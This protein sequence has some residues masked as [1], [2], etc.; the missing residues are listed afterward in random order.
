MNPMQSELAPPGSG[1]P[2]DCPE[3]A[4]VVA[5]AYGL[6]RREIL[7]DGFRAE[8]FRCRGHLR[9]SGFSSAPYLTDGGVQVGDRFSPESAAA[10][11]AHCLEETGAQ[12]VL[13]RA[14]R[15]LFTPVADRLIVDPSFETYVLPLD[16]GTER[17]WKER[18]HGK[19]R[20]QIRKGQ[21]QKLEVRIGHLDLLDSFFAVITEA[22]RDLGTPS[23]A[24]DYF[25]RILTVFGDQRAAVVAVFHGS[26]P[27]STALLLVCGATLHHPYAA[28]LRAFND[29]S[30]NNVLYWSI[31]EYGCRRGCA[32]FDLGRSRVDQGTRRY[33]LSWGAEP[34]PLFYSYFLRPGA[35]VPDL[36]SPLFQFATAVWQRMPLAATR[37]LGPHLIR[38]IL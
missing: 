18:I 9:S 6:E 11:A 30:A 4:E 36:Q 2:A 29:L 13:L 27:I 22:W 12:H 21:R 35:H 17:I 1:L 32:T 34:V 16:I 10:A 37:R 15:P 26:R 20:N 19:T 3:W 25:R 28:T 24:R 5:G 33:K 8:V 23:H 31:I 38:S 14:R 7:A